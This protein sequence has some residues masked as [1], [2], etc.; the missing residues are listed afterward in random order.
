[1]FS[2]KYNGDRDILEKTRVS[3]KPAPGHKCKDCG[4]ES[5]LRQIGLGSYICSACLLKRP[6]KVHKDSAPFGY[7][8]VDKNVSLEQ[9]GQAEEHNVN[10]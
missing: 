3:K 10:A 9:N 5:D 8:F 2:Y 4:S 6:V 1:M 7:T